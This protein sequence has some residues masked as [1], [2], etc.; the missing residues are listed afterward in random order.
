MSINYGARLNGRAKYLV[1]GQGMTHGTAYRN[2][3]SIRDGDL[4]AG[5]P[6]LKALDFLDASNPLFQYNHA[7][8]SAG[9]YLGRLQHRVATGIFSKRPGVTILTDSGGL[10]YARGVH[11]WAGDASRE[12]TLRFA[13]ANGNEGIAL[14]IPTVAIKLN[15]PLFSSPQACLTTTLENLTYWS[16]LLYTSPSPRD[17]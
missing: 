2:P 12:W 3:A 1:A 9:Q 8:L 16:C 6:G 5:L 11:Q 17:S 15:H 10:Q 14:D 4:P 13:E 7:L